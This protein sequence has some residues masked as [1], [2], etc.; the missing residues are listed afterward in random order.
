MEPR[1]SI[2]ASATL[3]RKFID[4]KTNESFQKNEFDAMK[5]IVIF[6]NE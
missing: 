1:S 4:K 2:F 5:H 6:G 3:S